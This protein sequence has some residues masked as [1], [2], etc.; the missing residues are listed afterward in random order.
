MD[1]KRKWQIP[2]FVL[3]LL[4]LCVF[5]F[6][7]VRTMSGTPKVAVKAKN[8]ERVKKT[9]AEDEKATAP[10]ERD[11][12]APSIVQRVSAPAESLASIELS[13][14]DPFETL[15]ALRKP[16]KA[17]SAPSRPSIPAPSGA[18]TVKDLVPAPAP[19]NP[20]AGFLGGPAGPA[21]V[22]A[23]GPGPAAAPPV[24]AQPEVDLRGTVTGGGRR[25]A[26]V[27]SGG[28]T[29]SAKST[30]LTEGDSIGGGGASVEKI[31]RDGITISGPFGSATVLPHQESKPSM[32]PSPAPGGK[33]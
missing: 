26:V 4:L 27:R 17:A 16:T 5:G 10:A 20:F 9:P 31:Q 30:F 29:S 28:A 23:V 14:I 19:F 32:R 7:A 18:I 11:A 3:G 15:P 2:V 13:P 21:P 22:K 12:T 25:I 8:P 33:T 24:P 1:K 6:N